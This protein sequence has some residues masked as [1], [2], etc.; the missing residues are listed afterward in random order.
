MLQHL[1]HV[2][3][4][5]SAFERLAPHLICPRPSNAKQIKL[6]DS[7]SKQWKSS[8]WKLSAAC[9]KQMERIHRSHPCKHRYQSTGFWKKPYSRSLAKH[10]PMLSFCGNKGLS[11]GSS[12]WQLEKLR[13]YLMLLLAYKTEVA[14]FLPASVQRSVQTGREIEPTHKLMLWWRRVLGILWIKGLTDMDKII[15]QPMK[16]FHSKVHE[17]TTPSFGIKAN[18]GINWTICQ[19][20]SSSI[21]CIVSENV[22]KQFHPPS[23]TA[24][25]WFTELL[26]GKKDIWL[27]NS[28]PAYKL[29]FMGNRHE[30]QVK[31]AS[32]W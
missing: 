23:S 6:A 17:W 21:T 4:Q 28:K 32:P 19:G 30:K 27:V 22:W 31:Y 16:L 7:R 1:N 3:K 8:Y 24:M 25:G 15:I 29:V 12:G 11:A 9:L 26:P 20:P 13:H 18:P 5:S 14:C 2:C 10:I